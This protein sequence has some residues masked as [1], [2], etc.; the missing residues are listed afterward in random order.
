MGGHD[1]TAGDAG[2]GRLLYFFLGV[3]SVPRPEFAAWMRQ[4]KVKDATVVINQD[5]I[6]T[7]FGSCPDAVAE[8][9]PVG[10]TMKVWYKNKQGALTPKTI[11]GRAVE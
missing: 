10:S 1:P 6:C 3:N 2:T 4:N 9:L 5:Y 11:F 7:G 8:I